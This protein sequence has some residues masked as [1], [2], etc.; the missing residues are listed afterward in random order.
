MDALL[1]SIVSVV[2]FGAAAT[3]CLHSRRICPVLQVKAGRG[4]L[5]IVL[6]THEVHQAGA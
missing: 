5:E 6:S 4:D 2:A 1:S 3:A